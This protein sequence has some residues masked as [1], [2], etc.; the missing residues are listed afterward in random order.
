LTRFVEAK[1]VKPLLELATEALFSKTAVSAKLKKVDPG[2]N[3]QV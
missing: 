2:R 1:K 3:A